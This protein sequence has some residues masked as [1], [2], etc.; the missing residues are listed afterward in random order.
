MFLD[1]VLYFTY[2]KDSDDWQAWPF[3]HPF[4]LI[5][6]LAVGGGWGGAGGPTDMT[7]FPTRMEIDYARM[8]KRQS[9]LSVDN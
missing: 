5:L 6:N 2:L 8:Y 1:G 4:H 9:A 7:V 3:D